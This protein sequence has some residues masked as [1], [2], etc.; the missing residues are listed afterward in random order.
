MNLAQ[1]TIIETAI[2]RMMRELI[3]KSFCIGSNEGPEAVKS[4][5]RMNTTTDSLTISL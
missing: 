4:K 2:T 3:T 1:L 5:F